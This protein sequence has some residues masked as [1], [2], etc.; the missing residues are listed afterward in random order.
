MARKRTFD[1]TRFDG[2]MSDDIRVSDLSKCALVSHFDIYCDPHKLVPMP[3]FVNDH[4]I[5]GDSTGL[6]AYSVRAFYYDGKNTN[7]LYAV[8][9]VSGGG[10][11][12]LWEKATPTTSEWTATTTG[13]GT[14]DLTDPTILFRPSS[15]A[16]LYYATE[17]SGTTYLSMYNGTV[18]DKDETLVASSISNSP[19]TLIEDEALSTNYDVYFNVPGSSKVSAMSNDAFTTTAKDTAIFPQSLAV[20]GEYVG[21]FG[22]L[23]NPSKTS[24]QLWDANSLLVDR[25]VDFGFGRAIDTN[26]VGNFWVGVV[27][28]GLVD[29]D[30]N[31]SE[32]VNGEYNLSIKV[33][34]GDQAT[35]IY[36]FKGTTQTNAEARV[37]DGKA[38]DLMMFHAR[39]PTDATPTTYNEGVFAVGR[40]KPGSPLAVSKLLD[41]GSLGSVQAVYSFGRHMFFAHAGDGSVSRLDSF[42]TGTYDVDCIYDT[43]MF[44]HD[45]PYLKEF[46]GLAVLTEDLPSGGEVEVFYRFDE[47]DSWTTLGTSDTDGAEIHNFTRA[48]GVPIGKFREIQFRIQITGNVT[49]K[50]IY[51]TLHESDDLPWNH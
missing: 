36:T 1:I 25:T 27:N 48:S 33:A 4:A 13:E 12:K 30:N 21:I 10:G 43:L 45:T 9:E 22:H 5:S 23:S 40:C 11:S 7:K 14:D 3:G 44:G 39:I 46:K 2:G 28:E 29:F 18:T 51:I 32:Y 6:K 17:A 8:G 50:G 26:Y 19:F 15:S 38:R 34:E 16:S 47:D 41:T 35:N 31:F 37:I 42:A 24:L 49:V 20:G